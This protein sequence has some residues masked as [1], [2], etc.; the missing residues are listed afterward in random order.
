MVLAEELH[1]T[2]AA[3][4]LHMSPPP[5]TQRIKKLEAQTGVLL[6]H[7]TKRAVALTPAGL[8]L[9]DEARKLLQQASHV[10]PMLQRAARGEAG[11]IRVGVAGSAIFSHAKRM[12]REVSKHLP[13]VRLIWHELSSVEQIESIRE[14]R[15]DVGLLNTPIEHRGVALGQPLREPLVAV[16]STTHRL[17]SR[18]TIELKALRDEVFIVGARHLSPGYY[19][20]FISACNVAGFAPNVDHQAGHLFTYISLVSIGAGVSLVPASMAD[21]GLAGVSYVRIRGSPLTSEV[22]LAWSKTDPSPV[23]TRVLRVMASAASSRAV[24]PI[25]RRTR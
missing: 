14:K 25:A 4:R 1:F 20:R 7:R 10:A 16:M 5:L 12:Q 3:A 23:T 11:S 21:A 19:D 24:S 9:L 8:V 2:R 17:A 6:F 18:S 15:L 13:E 22:S